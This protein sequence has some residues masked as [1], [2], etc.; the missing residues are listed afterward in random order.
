MA[1]STGVDSILPT[2]ITGRAPAGP[3]EVLLNP[4]LAKRL[5]RKIGDRLDLRQADPENP[6]QAGRGT[7]PFEVVGLGTLPIADGRINI[8][9]ALTLEGMASVAPNS[10]PDLA[11]LT[12]E[13]DADRQ[14]IRA[15]LVAAGAASVIDRTPPSSKLI[16]L[17]TKQVAT[18]PRIAAGLFAV[19]AAAVLARSVVSAGRRRRR[20]IAIFRA[21]GFSSRQATLAAIS[22]GVTAAFVAVALSVPIGLAM[23]ARLWALYAQS[24]GVKV[25]SSRPG[26]SIGIVVAS[27]L[28][29]AA[30]VAFL[31]GWYAARRA[32]ATTL[33]AE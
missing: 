27:G 23:G 32:T 18:T 7:L 28:L 30:V 2:V 13:P 12:L 5:D 33:R 9:F 17:D 16:Q 3:T 4:I 14:L 21:L 15:G 29:G 20:E 11:V 31:P 1:F 24:I 22:Q 6:S 26:R 8:G 10:G 19:T 25:E